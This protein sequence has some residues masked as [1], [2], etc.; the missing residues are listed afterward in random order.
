MLVRVIPAD[1]LEDL[2][3]S[4]VRHDCL[5]HRVAG[6]TCSVFHLYARDRR[7]AAVELRLFV[8]A[9]TMRHPQAQVALRPNSWWA[10]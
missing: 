8:E 4:L 7:E 2:I 5:V 9:W 3:A 6:D 1:Y 10:S